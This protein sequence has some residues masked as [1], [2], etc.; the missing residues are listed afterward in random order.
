M[1]TLAE[2]AGQLLTIGFEGQECGRELR[3]LLKE[4]RP[5]GVIFFQ[6]NIA[7]AEQFRTLMIQ[8]R[9]VLGTPHPFLGIDQEGGQVDRFRELLGPL[10]SARDAAQ[11]GLAFELG[12]LAGRELAAFGL[13]VDFAPVLDIGSP[14]SRAILGTRTAGDIPE[15][16]MQ[17]ATGF[18]R[19]LSGWN[20]LSCGKHFPGL[21]SGLKDS[22]LAMPVIETTEQEIRE[23]DVKPYRSLVAGLPMV[24]VAHAWYPALEQA[25]ASDGRPAAQPI[26][27]SL[28]PNIIQ[29][30]LRG[31]IGYRGLAVC[32]DL[33]MGGVL[34]GR[35]VEEAAVEAVRAGC[36]I[37]LVCRH[38]EHVERVHTALVCKSESDSSFHEQVARTA[39][40]I[41][42]QKHSGSFEVGTELVTFA[43]LEKLRRDIQ[44]FGER[45]RLRL[46]NEADAPDEESVET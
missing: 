16:V 34:E 32:D 43:D 4:V 10:P 2:Q 33:E 6:R 46:E 35:T 39:Q 26:P 37:L 3:S 44:Q 7:T 13:N 38:A 36:E 17:F 22:H 31:Q 20:V 40:R 28:S 12:D 14:D 8:I 19:G 41:Q 25:L 29:G 18:L 23:R 5:G 21:G 27:A 45:I 1:K 11:A 24:M 15:Q 30:L 42:V 9:E